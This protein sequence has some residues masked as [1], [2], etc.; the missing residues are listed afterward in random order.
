MCL[1]PSC[2]PIKNGGNLEDCCLGSGLRGE[3]LGGQVTRLAATCHRAV[4]Y[5]ELDSRRSRWLGSDSGV[6]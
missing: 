3:G 6:V 1:D 4:V 2:F 5:T